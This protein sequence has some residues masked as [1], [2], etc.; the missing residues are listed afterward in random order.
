[1]KV[2]KTIIAMSAS[3]MLLSGIARSQDSWPK[4]FKSS[5]GSLIS[6]YEPQPESFRGNVLRERAAFSINT[7]TGQDPVFGTFWMVAN[8]ETDRDSRTVHIVSVKVPNLKLAHDSATASNNIS[9]LKTE[10]ESGIPQL[11][12][13]LSLDAL[14]ASLDMNTEEKSL[15]KGLN[16]APPKIIYQSQPS[17]LVLI[18]GQPIIQHNNDLGFDAVVNTPYTIIKYSDGQFYLYGGKHWYMGTSAV[19]PFTYTQS[20]P[21]G[22][23]SVQKTIDDAN[24]SSTEYIDS[25]AASDAVIS[26]IIVSTEPAELLQSNG[27]PVLTPIPG[28]ALDYVSNSSNDIFLDEG[29][30]QYYIL[31]SGRWYRSANL[32][33]TWQYVASD[34]LPAGFA[35]IPE[36]SPKDRVLASVAGTNAAKEA[37]MDAQIPQTA[38]VDRKTA[39][40]DVNYDGSPQFADI[41]GTHM[42]YA[43]NSPIPVISYNGNYFSVDK[44]V[45]FISSGPTGPWH[46]STT[47]PGEVDLIPPGSPVYNLKFVYIYDVNP[48]WV[49]MGYTPGY[50][51]TFIYGPTVVYGTGFYYAPWRGHFFYPRP[52]TWG[53]NMWYNPWWGWTFGFDYGWDWFNWDMGFGW[54]FWFGGWW[55]PV[56]YRP[57][58]FGHYFAPHGFYGRNSFAAGNRIYHNNNNIYRGRQ[59]VSPRE[60]P[61]RVTTDRMGNIYRQDGNGNWQQRDGRNWAP[62]DNR[63]QQTIQNLN[64]QQQMRERGA[65]R[66]QN[67]QMS[68]SSGGGFRSGGGRHR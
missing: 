55:G 34:A 46:V 53:F 1:M 29:T 40:T 7:G 20:I 14:L 61:Q 25:S 4:S 38:K 5:D 2:F 49:Y 24:N 33:G 10:I 48:D 3:I 65:V 52:W 31:L 26:N 15:S 27:A 11:N 64:R 13:D 12:I 18:D 50:L 9:F 45:W 58:Y 43:V 32:Q 39:T 35:R 36:G 54:G 47:R 63:Q 28:T 68:R 6:I 30:H 57:P 37:M 62:V 66:S 41:P 17:L 51:N 42:Q 23:A 21:S 44:G 60:I 8:V 22:L 67:F 59:G 19:G 56:I 16:T